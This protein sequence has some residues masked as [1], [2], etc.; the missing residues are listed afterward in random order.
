MY[1]PPHAVPVLI[2]A[3][4]LFGSIGLAFALMWLIRKQPKPEAP[5]VEETPEGKVTVLERAK[6]RGKEVS[7]ERSMKQRPMKHVVPLGPE[8]LEDS[9]RE[10]EEAEETEEAELEDERAAAAH[11]R[12]DEH[13]NV[14]PDFI[15][16][17]DTSLSDSLECVD[18]SRAKAVLAMGGVLYKMVGPNEDLA[19]VRSA[20]EITPDG[21][22]F[23]LD[24]REKE[25]VEGKQDSKNARVT[26][27]HTPDFIS[28]DDEQFSPYLHQIEWPG[29]ERLLANG[30][31]NVYGAMPDGECMRIKHSDQIGV[32]VDRDELYV[33]NLPNQA[34]DP[35]K[36]HEL[37]EHLPEKDPRFRAFMDCLHPVTADEAPTIQEQ[38]GFV[39]GTTAEGT[40]VS[41][42]RGLIPPE[43]TLYRLE[44]PP[45][46]VQETKLHNGIVLDHGRAP[47]NFHPGNTPNYFVKLDTG[48]RR[49]RVL[50]G[51][52]LERAMAQGGVERGD[53]ATFGNHGFRWVD[54]QVP[55]GKSGA[56]ETRTVKRN[57]WEAKAAARQATSLP[58]DR[59]KHQGRAQGV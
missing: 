49:P 32:A 22:Y 50:W 55:I 20:D 14:I 3:A 51:V 52:D 23:E 16:E 47:Y 17:S 38:G 43:A 31:K 4:A 48:D 25:W 2:G 44:L 46:R 24:T 6:S 29:A 59:G 34:L 1:L 5:P 18:V 56:T 28:P 21:G 8:L 12:R 57:A 39:Y 13:A 15:P 26:P 9:R 19:R 58:D 54:V 36:L 10:D 11:K 45:L 42:V 33:L 7:Q 40:G 27:L 30:A 35:N 41:R 53:V 37:P